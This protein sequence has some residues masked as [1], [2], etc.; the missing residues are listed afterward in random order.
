MATTLQLLGTMLSI[1]LGAVPMTSRHRSFGSVVRGA[2]LPPNGSTVFGHECANPPC[3]VTNIL[4]ASVYPTGGAPA[5]WEH[6][7]IS[8]FVDGEPNASI[9]VTALELGWTSAFAVRNRSSSSGA[10]SGVDS[11][12]EFLLDNFGLPWGTD[13]F[14]HTAATGGIYSTLR[15]PFERSLRVTVQP[16]AGSTGPSAVWF[17]L[18]GVESMPI[19]LGELQLPPSAKLRVHRVANRRLAQLELFTIGEAERGTSGAVLGTLADVVGKGFGFLEG[20]PRFYASARPDESPIYLSSGAEDYFL[21]ASYFNNGVY[22]TSQAGLTFKDTVGGVGMYKWH[23]DRDQLLFHDGFKMVW[24]NSDAGCSGCQPGTNTSA[25][26]AYCEPGQ[27][28]LEAVAEAAA[29]TDEQRDQAHSARRSNQH[30]CGA[31]LGD[32]HGC[33]CGPNMTCPGAPSPGDLTAGEA[34]YSTLVYYYVFPS[35]D[36]PDDSRAGCSV[37]DEVEKLHRLRLRGVLTAAE[38]SDAKA[39]LLRRL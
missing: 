30:G 37:A 39:A 10:R 12:S 35:S 36:L 13:T 27:A 3:A 24:R 34:V 31:P 15:V 38:F 18:R 29:L 9:A 19:V 33:R 22:A 16:V 21:S 25:P 20:C 28:G 8:F 2:A 6:A 4:F 1:S 5:A 26:C 14:G 32:G 23:G 17:D 7:T 11:Q